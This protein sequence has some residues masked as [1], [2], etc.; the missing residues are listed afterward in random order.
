MS[1]DSIGSETC[2]R[3]CEPIDEAV[4]PH[5]FQHGHVMRLR[6]ADEAVADDATRV[7]PIT[8]SV[9]TRDRFG[10]NAETVSSGDCVAL[11]IAQDGRLGQAEIAQQ[12]VQLPA[13]VVPLAN[14]LSTR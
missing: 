7:R 1:A 8:R 3:V 5:L 4:A 12:P 2:V 10:S 9:S 11:R 14:A 13:R 6:H